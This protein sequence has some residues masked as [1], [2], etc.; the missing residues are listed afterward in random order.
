MGF[1]IG[2]P[3][4]WSSSSWGVIYSPNSIQCVVW[5]LIEFQRWVS[6]VFVLV[7]IS[8]GGG[9]AVEFLLWVLVLLDP[10]LLDLELLDLELL[11]LE[12]LE[13]VLE[14]WLWLEPWL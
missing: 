6:S 14:L 5:E 7:W 10:G 13:L 9:G 12:L 11:D 4:G 8:G 1:F 3:L 2:G